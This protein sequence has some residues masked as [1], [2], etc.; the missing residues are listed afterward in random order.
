[1]DFLADTVFLIDLWR[2]ARSPGRATRFAREH[3]GEQ[4]GINWVVA[5][6]FLAGA[7][8]AGQDADGVRRFLERYPLVQSS[9]SIIQRY[10]EIYADLKRSNQLIGPNDLWIAASCS[11]FDKP[12]LT[13]NVDEFQRVKGLRVVGY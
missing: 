7:E 11:A 10:A 1:M 5:G 3:E 6:E 12:I 4:V 2:E 13:R 9:P 8:A